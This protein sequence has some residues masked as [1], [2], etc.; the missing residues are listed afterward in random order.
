MTVSGQR[1]RAENVAASGPTRAQTHAVTVSLPPG[2][3]SFCSEPGSDAVPHWYATPPYSVA[4]LKAH[5]G[6]HADELEY[7]VTAPTWPQLRTAV[8]KQVA[9]YK[10]LVRGSS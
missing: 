5:F 1:T 6:E 7:T 3:S 9:L 4:A 2:W 10:S 8:R